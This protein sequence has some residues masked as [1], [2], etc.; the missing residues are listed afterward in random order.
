MVGVLL[1]NMLRPEPGRT[2]QTWR[3]IKL[4]SIMQL[5]GID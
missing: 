5:N 4:L 2:M 1:S 3:C